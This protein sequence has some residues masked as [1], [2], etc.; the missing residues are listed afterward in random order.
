MNDGLKDK[1]RQAII[2]ILAA[3]RRVKR[4]ALFG[5][6]AMGTFTTTSDVD[7]ALYGDELTLTDQAKLA[8]VIDD[9][10]MA[11]RV[12][13]L[14]YKTIDNDN[15]K[16]HIRKYGV[17]WFRR[18]WVISSN[19]LIVPLKDAG[20]SLIDC[21]HKTPK[22]QEEGLPYIG[23]PQ[24][25]EGHIIINGARLIN[26]KDFHQWRRKAKP[27]PN[28]VIL[29]RRCNPG[30]TAYV[31]EGL[32]IALGQNLVLLRSDG[33]KLYPPFLRWVVQGVSWWNQIGKFINVGAVFDSLKCADIPNLE[34]KLP[35]ME[36]QKNITEILKIEKELER[37]NNSIDYLEGKINRMSHQIKY[38]TITVETSAELKAGIVGSFFTGIYKGVKW[39]FVR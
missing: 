4:V 22:A 32:D 9:L 1:H 21:D 2:D 5:S 13:L 38:A 16:K 30:E 37:L 26:E 39:L 8:A 3:N 6:R 7:L 28:D 20:V 33:E 34:V 23:I 14:L 31:P 19:W 12:D 27:A 29:S 18:G 24:L 25:K 11:Q 15:L 17:E 35:P 36:S 10:P